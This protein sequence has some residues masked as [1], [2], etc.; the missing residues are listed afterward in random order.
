MCSG[1]AGT[2]GLRSCI[3]ASECGCQSGIFLDLEVLPGWARRQ[4]EGQG[5]LWKVVWV[6]GVQA[7]PW[8]KKRRDQGLEE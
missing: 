6:G 4:L 3:L 1:V 8:L 7:E 2:A 5:D